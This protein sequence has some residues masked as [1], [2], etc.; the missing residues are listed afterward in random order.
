MEILAR[1]DRNF[2]AYFK[3]VSGLYDSFSILKREKLF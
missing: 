2:N 3:Y 1:W